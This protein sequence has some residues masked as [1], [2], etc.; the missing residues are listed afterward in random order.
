MHV[1]SDIENNGVKIDVRV[2][3]DNLSQMKEAALALRNEMR[4]LPGLIALEDDLPLF[5]SHPL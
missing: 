2:I 1:L 4:V 5:F 3:G